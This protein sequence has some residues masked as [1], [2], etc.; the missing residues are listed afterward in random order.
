MKN[1]NQSPNLREIITRLRER[2]YQFWFADAPQGCE[3]ELIV[4]L[5]GSTRPA[6]E[7]VRAHPTETGRRVGC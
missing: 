7:T 6:F 3:V 4:E 5:N 2:N 1:V